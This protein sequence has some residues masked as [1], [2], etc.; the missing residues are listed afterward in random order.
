M[1]GHFVFMGLSIDMLRERYGAASV[2]GETEG[3][4]TAG[5]G[6]Y[7]SR[8]NTT[9]RVPVIL[10]EEG[11]RRLA[12][13]R[14]DLIPSWWSKPA[15][16]KK[17]AAYNA[18]AASIE[19][20]ATFSGAWRACRRCIIPATGFFEWP[21]KTLMAR[22]APRVEHRIRVTGSPIFSLAGLWDECEKGP[23]KGLRS[24]TIITTAA[25][26]LMASIP[27]PRMPVILPLED[28][29]AWLS[30]DTPAGEARKLLRRFPADRM[31]IVS[32]A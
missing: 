21:S 2:G 27:H 24:C 16:E 26:S 6:F 19:E 10:E 14:W 15:S 12:F 22:D 8:G 13:L 28:E 32:G 3:D 20:K 5:E 18:R 1:C 31:E 29:A 30:T 11:R 17:F 9:R 23:L 25:N 4:T 7:P